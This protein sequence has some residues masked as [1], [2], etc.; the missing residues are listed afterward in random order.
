MGKLAREII[1]R[2]TM[3]VVAALL[4][5]GGFECVQVARRIDADC[6]A[7]NPQA[8]ISRTRERSAS[9]LPWAFGIGLFALGGV[10]GLAAVLPVNALVKVLG[11]HSPPVRTG[12][13]GGGLGSDDWS[14][15]DWWFP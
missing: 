13:N 15:N 14:W 8:S 3:G 7:R 9:G 12:D 6:A 2:T 4:F 5:F 11:P 10:M 1:S